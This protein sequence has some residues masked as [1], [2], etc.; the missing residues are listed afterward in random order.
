MKGMTLED[1]E[2]RLHM[3]RRLQNSYAKHGRPV[4]RPLVRPPP[5]RNI[6]DQHAS[7]A[8]RL[9]TDAVN[10]INDPY[11]YGSR[12]LVWSASKKKYAWGA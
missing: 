9:A 10:T 7:A 5:T 12:K 4:T 2:R 1:M 6:R 8:R 11:S 3:N